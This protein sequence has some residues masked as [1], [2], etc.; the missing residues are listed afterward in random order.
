MITGL[1]NPGNAYWD[2]RHNVGFDIADA[3][4]DQ[5]GQGEVSKS[6]TYEMVE[7]RFKGQ[8]FLVMKPMTFMNRS[9]S[10]VTK[11]LAH[12]QSVLEDMIVCYDDLNLPLGEIR[13]KENGSAGGHNGIQDIIDQTGTRE[14]ARL[15][16][17]IGNDF[18]RGMQVEYVL[19]RF[20]TSEKEVV[21]QS[22][23]QAVDAL[24]TYIRADLTTAMN[25]FNKKTIKPKTQT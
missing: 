8:S 22:I 16:F 9:G 10:A 14:F 23:D 2:T 4:I 13:M 17:G 7:C 5:Y 19:S 18:P 11:A 15:R 25:H 21:D 3:L 6:G 24:T 20:S 1:G 12:S